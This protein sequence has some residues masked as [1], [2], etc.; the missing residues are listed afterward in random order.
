MIAR[1]W[2]EFVYRVRSMFRRAD[3]ERELDAELRSHIEHETARLVRD[4][5]SPT[6]A[7]RQA[8]ASFGGIE[9][10]KE[11]TRDARGVSFVEQTLADVRYA[12]RALRA[13]KAFT[14]GVVI[15]LALG[16]GANATMFGIVDRLLFRAPSALRD[17]ETVHRLYRYE[18]DALEVSANRSFSYPTYLDL[19]RSLTSFTDVAAFYT[20]RYSVGDGESVVELPVTV[21]SANY[22]NYFDARPFRGRFFTAAEDSAEGAQV[23]V[24]GYDFWQSQF[25][26]RDVIG[27]QIRVG[28]PLRTIIGVA[29]RGFVGV[30]DQGVPA[31]WLPISNFA[32]ASRGAAYTTYYEWSWLE[33]I[34]RRRLGV[35]RQAAE[36]EL[37]G[38]FIR[39]W[40]NA[41]AI[42]KEWGTPEA[43]DLRGAIGPIQLERGPQAGEN[44]RVAKWTAGVALIVLLIACANVANLLLARALGRRREIA[45]RLALGASRGRLARQLLTESVLLSVLGAIGGLAIAQWGATSIRRWFIPSEVTVNVFTDMRMVAFAAAATILVALLTGLVPAVRSGRTDVSRSLKDGARGSSLQHSRTRSSLLILQV[46]LSV[47]LLIGAGLFVRSLSNANDYRLGYDADQV[48]FATTRLR[49]SRLTTA[50]RASLFD[51]LENAARA[52]PGVTHVTHAQS[53]PFSGNDMRPLASPGVD[54]ISA[55]G[56]FILQI[57]SPDYF[58]TMGTRI[59]RGRAFGAG[60][61]LGSERVVVVSEGMANAIWPGSDP[62]GKCLRFAWSDTAPCMTVVGVAEEMHLR[63]FDDSREHAYY[64]PRLQMPDEPPQLQLLARVNG[65]PERSIEALRRRLQRELPGSAYIYVRPL[66]QLVEPNLRSWRLGATMF[67][68]FGALALVLAAI[69]LH[70]VIAYDMAQ[71]KRDLSLRVALGAPTSRLFGM[72]V[73]RGAR[74]VTVGLVLGGSVAMW[75]APWLKEQ[76]FQQ[77]PRDLA[78]FGV[79]G[80]TLLIA[81][82]AA[83]LM[84]AFRAARVDPN[85]VLRDE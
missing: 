49:G 71:R 13:H 43:G 9:R 78:V 10:I 72:V 3:V 53:V 5:V 65:A 19:K 30:S 39:S 28:A 66:M 82:V 48:L 80:L 1:V 79:V 42:N 58:A 54:S 59:V 16:I 21:A 25:G 70:S 81:G 55:R 4:G 18:R 33:V 63:S 45:V 50:E 74:L 20:P 84:P 27:E 22:F 46:A 85:Q 52:V 12:L 73:G 26:G 7:E 75:A 14:I 23:V 29:P 38:A 37:T 64:V 35:T 62:L 8:R 40:R 24:L 83:T 17:P 41:Y 56:R 6:D 2:S 31:M 47:V 15:T 44:S 77:D 60:D 61:R 67:T 34:A 36:T 32:F 11:D 69:G 57:G 68:A 76:L 51:R